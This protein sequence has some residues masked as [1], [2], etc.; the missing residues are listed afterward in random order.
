MVSLIGIIS[1][2][3][4]TLLYLAFVAPNDV[5]HRIWFIFAAW[6]GAI[7]FVYWEEEDGKD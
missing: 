6:V 4:A 5:M 3:I 7:G 2:A 1:I